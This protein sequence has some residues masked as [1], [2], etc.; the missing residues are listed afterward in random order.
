VDVVIRVIVIGDDGRHH[1]EILKKIAQGKAAL[2][3][4]NHALPMFQ[5]LVFEDI[6]FGVFPKI[7]AQVFDMVGRWAKNSV[8]DVLEMVMQM[9]EVRAL[10]DSCNLS[11]SSASQSLAFIHSRLVAHRVSGISYAQLFL[12]LIL[13]R[14]F[15]ST[16]SLF[17]GT[18]SP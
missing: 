11:L 9:L 5:Q 3:S 1:L 8:G 4:T 15:F 18:P 14:M 6:V 12:L 7:G 16:T 10:P 2:H 13:S 17:S